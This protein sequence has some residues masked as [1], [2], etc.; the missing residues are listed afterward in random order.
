MIDADKRD[1]AER[2]RTDCD[3]DNRYCDEARKDG[4]ARMAIVDPQETNPYPISP[5]HLFSL[6]VV[7][8]GAA[9]RSR[10]TER[11]LY[12]MLSDRQS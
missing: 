10:R 5:I 11:A 2:E 1:E 3:G 4:D 8:D 9:G 7:S 12:A 6:E